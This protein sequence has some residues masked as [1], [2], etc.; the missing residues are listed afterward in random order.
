MGPS[1]A[2][3]CPRD[4]AVKYRLTA[5]VAAGLLSMG[6]YV[7]PVAGGYFETTAYGGG[8]AYNVAQYTDAELLQLQEQHPGRYVLFQYTDIPNGSPVWDAVATVVNTLQA[9]KPDARICI[10]FRPDLKYK[11]REAASGTVWVG[12][13]S[14]RYCAASTPNSCTNWQGNLT[15]CQGGSNA[16]TRCNVGDSTCTGG[17]TCG[18]ADELF[19]T[20]WIMKTPIAEWDA[21]ITDRWAGDDPFCAGASDPYASCAGATSHTWNTQV[22]RDA[23]T[24]LI[25]ASAVPALYGD[26]D[27]SDNMI[28]NQVVLDLRTEAAR[29]WKVKE[30]VARLQDAGITGSENGCLFV[31]YKPGWYSRYLGATSNDCRGS[32]RTFSGYL[33]GATKPVACTD[34]GP[35]PL[36]DSQYGEGEF[37]AAIDDFMV[38]LDAALTAASMPNVKILVQEAPDNDNIWSSIPSL[39]TSS[40]FIGE[41]NVITAD[42]FP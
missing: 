41:L 6:Q 30:A 15:T 35:M 16:G 28:V 17:G 38:K 27:G 1:V 39:R 5:L 7:G 34:E 26:N 40:R 8:A 3:W 4:H 36:Q 32:A 24:D 18:A 31:G 23:Y 19:D 13:S 2:G 12:G 11:F 25:T 29:A 33:W 9:S 22:D 42:P 14:V 10:G 21:L 37:E 20:D